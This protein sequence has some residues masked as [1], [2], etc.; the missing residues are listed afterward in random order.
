M[1][2]AWT[3]VELAGHPVD[4]FDP[5]GPD[6]PRRA[7]LFLHDDDGVTLRDRPG[8]ARPLAEA[9]VGVACPHGG[10]C[11]WA[12]RICPAFDPALTPERWL[13]DHV[14]PFARARWPLGPG[15]LGL[16]GV[17][18]GGQGALRLAF[19]HPRLFPVVAALGASLDHHELMHRGTPLDEMYD[20]TEQCRQDTA[21]LH[22]H[23]SHFP[24]RIFFAVDP[25][26]AAWHRGND[27]LHEKLSAL[28]I[29]HEF[30]ATTRAGGHTWAYYDALA[31]RAVRFVLDGLD[32]ESRRLV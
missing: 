11:W 26:D 4:L 21:L 25:T 30:E 18:M 19:K 29:T 9:G 15:A 24:P 23:P 7:V 5:P 17:G 13:L 22:V 6:R 32:R 10:P 3:T 8:F 12:D 16:L 28:G 2:G 31:E 27:R 1:S 20:S 14:V